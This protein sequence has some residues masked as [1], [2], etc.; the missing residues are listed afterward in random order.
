[1]VEVHQVVRDNLSHINRQ[2]SN[3]ARGRPRDQF[4]VLEQEQLAQLHR[5]KDQGLI[6]ALELR[7]SGDEMIKLAVLGRSEEDL[8]PFSKNTIVTSFLHT[9]GPR[10]KV[11]GQLAGL[12]QQYSGDI[13]NLIGT[14]D[15]FLPEP[16][17]QY[18]LR[19]IHEVNEVGSG[20]ERIEQQRKYVDIRHKDELQR[21]KVMLAE[22]VLRFRIDNE[23]L[24][25]Q[26]KVRF[27]AFPQRA[28]LE[29]V[30]VSFLRPGIPGLGFHLL[31]PR[32]YLFPNS[33]AQLIKQGGG[34]DLVTQRR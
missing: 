25:R 30:E 34:Y 32:L 17:E 5:E 23:A 12:R 20:I 27:L 33:V 10:Y 26:V 13:G 1:M 8:H 11:T 14:P 7:H 29:L 4:S 31:A 16:D 9:G 22:K 28:Q 24:G 6:S 18:L 15:D 21:L 2:I 19:T 3:L